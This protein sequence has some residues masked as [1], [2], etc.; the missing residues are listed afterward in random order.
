[1]ELLQ[2]IQQRYGDLS[3]NQRKIAHYIAS[4]GVEVSFD[5]II[6]LANKIGV[7]EPS[8]VRFAQ[9]LGFKGY[10]QFRKELQEE[11][12]RTIGSAA[13]LRRAVTDVPNKQFF[14][15]LLLK[16]V[17]FIEQTRRE[18][19]EK[20]LSQAIARIWQARRIFIVGFRSAFSLAYFLYFRFVRL[21]LDVRLAILTGG[22]SLIEQ[23]VLLGSQ[24]L[25][26]VIAFDHTPRETRTALDYA[27]KRNIP[28]LGVT[29]IRTSEIARKASVCLFARRQT[30]IT[31][32]LAA[33]MALLNALAIGVANRRKAK[34]L[35]ALRQLD[36]IDAELQA[37]RL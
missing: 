26:I 15:A 5:S 6:E 29:H 24:D 16:D 33:P 34:A 1:M 23:L 3:K 13:R 7:S 27:L 35:R 32:S 21:R 22:T 30:H 8:I 18:I 2:K 28:I 12:R 25:L 10:P 4:N 37:T 9:L 11:F 19:S 36:A 14:E 31:Q 20:D 17:E